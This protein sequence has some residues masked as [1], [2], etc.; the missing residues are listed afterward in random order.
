MSKYCFVLHGAKEETADA[1]SILKKKLGARFKLSDAAVNSLFNNLPVV[2]KKGLD[3]TQIAAYRK[4]FEQIGAIVEVVEEH[5]KAAGELAF[6][7]P[8][9]SSPPHSPPHT[10]TLS[11]KSTQ[12]SSHVVT[13]PVSTTP[14]LNSPPAQTPKATI[15]V[16]P[17]TT[18]DLSQPSMLSFGFDEKP[19]AEEQ[20]RLPTPP[21]KR[22]APSIPDAAKAELEIPPSEPTPPTSQEPSLS[23]TPSP[24]PITLVSIIRPSLGSFIRENKPL[25]IGGI[26][27]AILL[28]AYV[29]V[30]APTTPPPEQL[31]PEQMVDKLLRDQDRILPA[32]RRA[33]KKEKSLPG[34]PPITLEAHGT[35][36]LTKSDLIFEIQDEKITRID[37]SIASLPPSK[38]TPE[39]VVSG[40]IRK[41]WLERFSLNIDGKDIPLPEVSNNGWSF[42]SQGIGKAYLAD[43]SGRDRH[44]AIIQVSGSYDSN[45]K[46]L[47]GSW[48]LNDGQTLSEDTQNFSE[49]L[50]PGRI[51][52]LWMGNFVATSNAEGADTKEEINAK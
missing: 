28:L 19:Q 29:F 43:D 6:D 10:Q 12:T 40:I 39:L 13:P 26:V 3:E 36:E 27:I 4:V 49:R 2:I 9:A 34:G 15:P 38:L 17:E 16:A 46:Q 23:T 44:I 24:E 18:K 35:D 22:S 30:P 50:A 33:K 41:P 47:T 7:E 37:I 42:S 31:K 8:H 1:V 45:T 14:N 20:P 52:F 51:R 21:P 32:K 25:C 11:E 48:R 5:T